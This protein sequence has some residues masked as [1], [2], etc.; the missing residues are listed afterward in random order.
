M[1]ERPFQPGAKRPLDVDRP[2]LR[3]SISFPDTNE[4]S[5]FEGHLVGLHVL[6]EFTQQ[7]SK[8]LSTTE[9]QLFGWEESGC[10]HRKAMVSVGG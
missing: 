1:S 7:L 8:R 2:V 9:D 10:R 5:Y 4:Y 3:P 6:V